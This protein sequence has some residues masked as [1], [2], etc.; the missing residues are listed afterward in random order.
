[1]FGAMARWLGAAAGWRVVGRLPDLPKYMVIGA[2]HTTNWDFI[3]FLWVMAELRFHPTWLGK[4][5]IFWWPAGAV[6]RRLGGVPVKRGARLNVVD[7]VVE[8][9]RDADRMTLVMSPEGTRRYTSSWKSGFYHIARGAG[10]PIVPGKL[11]YPTRTVTIGQPMQMTGDVD[12]DMAG[13]RAF[14]TGARGMYPAK[15]S[16]IALSGGD[17]PDGARDGSSRDER[18]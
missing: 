6:W 11:D 16:E 5:G 1:V 4:D 9:F 14:Y 13:F 18:A 17:G 2:P 8:R 12:R 10:V 15:A 7:Q 3:L